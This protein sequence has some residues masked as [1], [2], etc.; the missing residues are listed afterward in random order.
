MIQCPKCKRI[1]IN[2]KFT[3]THRKH[4]IPGMS[5]QLCP[6]CRVYMNRMQIF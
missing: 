2:G 6:E 4:V 5:Y 3:M 1:R